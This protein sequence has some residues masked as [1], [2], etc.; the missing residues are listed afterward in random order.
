[1]KKKKFFFLDKT[2]NW[3]FRKAISFRLGGTKTGPSV[4]FCHG[5][6]FKLKYRYCVRLG[7]T[8]S[9]TSLKMHD[10]YFIFTPL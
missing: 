7:S 1:M 10:Y 9:N 2:T 8:F 3:S 6:V 4:F 5:F